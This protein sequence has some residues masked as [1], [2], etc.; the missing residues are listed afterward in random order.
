MPRIIKRVQQPQPHPSSSSF[1]KRE[2]ISLCISSSKST[3]YSSVLL[4][5]CFLLFP[6]DFPF[7]FDLD[8]SINLIVPSFFI[9]NSSELIFYI[10]FV[11]ALYC[12]T[13]SYTFLYHKEFVGD[14]L[15]KG[16]FQNVVELHLIG[17][18]KVS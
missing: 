12:H 17:L 5:L 16:Q 18:N 11:K 10:E 1:S 3:S 9:S 7:P 2:S 6:F 13:N 4:W 8:L 15:H 14:F